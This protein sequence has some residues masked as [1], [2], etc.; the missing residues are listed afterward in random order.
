MFNKS[1]SISSLV[2]SCSRTAVQ[3]QQMVN[4]F[5]SAMGLI[6][7]RVRNPLTHAP[8]THLLSHT[9]APTRRHKK[10]KKKK[11]S[12]KDPTLGF[13]LEL[14]ARVVQSITRARTDSTAS[15][16]LPIADGWDT[17]ETLQWTYAVVYEQQSFKFSRSLQPV[18]SP[19]SSL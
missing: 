6:E 17:V 8:E 14:P 1:C 10:K 15:F 16:E 18:H 12:Q 13:Q 4:M 5:N 3:Q 2:N 11:K 7:S 19:G 9:H